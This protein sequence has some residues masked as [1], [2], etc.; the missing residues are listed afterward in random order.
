MLQ[1]SLTTRLALTG[2]FGLGRAYGDNTGDVT[3]G[4]S[5]Y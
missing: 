3:V 5:I 2:R 4:I 1:L